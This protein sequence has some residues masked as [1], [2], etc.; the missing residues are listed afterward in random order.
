TEVEAPGPWCG[1]L[2]HLY[3]RHDGSAVEGSRFRI[4][5]GEDRDQSK[6][7]SIQRCTRAGNA[8]FS[9]KA[10]RQAIFQAH[11][12]QFQVGSV[13]AVG[14]HVGTAVIISVPGLDGYFFGIR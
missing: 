6:I 7:T 5:D 4:K 14:L 3:P 1:H 8:Q 2:S 12:T 10:A 11:F 9:R 13:E